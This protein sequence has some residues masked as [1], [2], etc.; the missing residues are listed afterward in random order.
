[1]LTGGA[2][3]FPFFHQALLLLLPIESEPF[4]VPL[5]FLPYTSL[6]AAN[7]RVFYG[8]YSILPSGNHFTTGTTA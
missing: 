7:R 6:V 3:R 8:R 4:V 2:G 1:V 5:F